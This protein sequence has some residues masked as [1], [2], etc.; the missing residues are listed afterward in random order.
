MSRHDLLHLGKE[1]FPP[2]PLALAGL[3]GIPDS[4]RSFRAMLLMKNW[5]VH[6]TKITIGSQCSEASANVWCTLR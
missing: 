1:H 4:D 6:A 5:N 2:R 3:I